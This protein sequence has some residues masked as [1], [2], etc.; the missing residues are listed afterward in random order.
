MYLLIISTIILDYLLIYFLPSFFNQISLFYPMLTL[1][2]IVFLYKK[3]DNKKYFKLVFIIG[4]IYDLLFSYIFLF[5]SLIFLM[6][7]KIIKKIDKYIRCNLFINIILVIIFIFLYDL[8]LFLL[9][10]ISD[11]NLVSLTDL[12]YKFKNSCILNISF[13]VLISLIL[14]NKKIINRKSKKLMTILK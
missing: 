9:V 12:I 1:T 8:I 2:L 10:L 14:R 13:Y 6:F 11:Y 3:F 4:F 5:N 7:A